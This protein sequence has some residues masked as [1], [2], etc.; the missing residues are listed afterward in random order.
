MDCAR[1][2]PRAQPV[3]KTAQ[4]PDPFTCALTELRC[5]PYSLKMVLTHVLFGAPGP[6]GRIVLSESAREHSNLR[7]DRNEAL[8]PHQGATKV[9]NCEVLEPKLGSR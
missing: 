1:R 2:C 4:D 3:T 9:Y 7:T 8:Q 6:I 5:M